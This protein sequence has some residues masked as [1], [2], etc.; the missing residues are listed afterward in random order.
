MVFEILLPMSLLMG[1]GYASVKLGLL[2]AEQI[3]GLGGYVIKIALPALILHSL[4]SKNL[5]EIWL[6]PYLLAYVGG[7]LILYAL[8]YWIYKRHFHHALTQTAVLSMGA[9][10]SNTGL[11][12]SAI[13]PLVLPNH[14]V[15]YL[16]LTLMIENL[17]M[18]PMVLLLAESGLQAQHH[19]S[20]M[21]YQALKNLLKNPL[22]ISIILAMLAVI[23]ELR[24]PEILDNVLNV[25]GKTAPSLALLVIGGSLVGMKLRALDTQT[26]TLV[27]LKVVLM[28]SVIFGLFFLLP[29]ASTEMQHA[30]TLIAALPMPIVFGILGQIYGLEQRAVAALMLS[31]LLGFM[32]ISLLIACWW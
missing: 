27:L 31:T 11:I 8:A 18:I 29:H 1:T 5:H 21:L 28:P 10:M 20:R 14:A 12:G 3:K 6:L 26:I 4:A 7:S 16:S 15:I 9:A 30:A 2:T 13:L 25:L 24:P 19:P 23:F 22:V 17:L 32:G